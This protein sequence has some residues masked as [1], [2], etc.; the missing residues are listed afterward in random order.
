MSE[1]PL[2]ALAG[3]AGDRSKDRSKSNHS[4]YFWNTLTHHYDA[5]GDTPRCPGAVP[6]GTI[7]QLE[8]AAKGDFFWPVVAT[9]TGELSVGRGESEGIEW[10]GEEMI[11]MTAMTTKSSI[12]EK[13]SDRRLPG[14]RWPDG[15]CMVIA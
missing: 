1:F 11:G 15:V 8:M 12:E 9:E 14:A 3:Y 13:P 10:A 4:V 2:Y 7:S 5:Q 6:E